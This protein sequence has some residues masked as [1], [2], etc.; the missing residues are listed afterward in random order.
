MSR[1]LICVGA[2]TAILPL[3]FAC[4]ATRNPTRPV[5]PSR[6]IELQVTEASPAKIADAETEPADAAAKSADEL[7]VAHVAGSRVDVR[8]LL[9]LWLF[10]DSPAVHDT[11]AQLV[12][13][14]FTLAEAAR[15]GMRIPDEDLEAAYQRGFEAL[16]Q[17]VERVSPGTT[18]DEYLMRRRG[19]DPAM[20]RERF[21][22]HSARA[23]ISERVVRTW[24][25]SNEH[26]IA[27]AIVCEDQSQVEEVEA[28]LAGGADFALLAKEMSHD[29]A[30]SGILPPIT[31]S[32]SPISRLGFV[33]PVGEI[34]G[35]V[36]QSGRFL[37]IKV[38]SRPEPLVGDWRSIGAE[39]ERS[40]D[41]RPVHEMEWMQWEEAM[42]TR[43]EVDTTPF[44][45]L[46]GEPLR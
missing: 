40:L 22:D 13:M 42:F 6:P 5:Q 34:G 37:L 30:S 26:V 44:L 12:S 1:P 35:P 10:R 17:E 15:L 24:L 8:E 16:A 29:P 31:R 11:L 9:D 33:T 45:K 46:V 18:V 27:R 14:R 39:V 4:G 7:T 41:Q 3:L 25:L 2:C 21:R 38:E 36:D 43:Y 20:Y 19:V 28:A 32:D 23:L